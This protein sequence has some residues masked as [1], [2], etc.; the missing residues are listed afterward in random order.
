[1]IEVTL[2]KRTPS[3]GN[4]ITSLVEKQLGGN[5]RLSIIQGWLSGGR[6]RQWAPHGFREEGRRARY[7]SAFLDINQLP[8]SHVCLSLESQSGRFVNLPLVDRIRAFYAWWHVGDSRAWV[9]GMWKQVTYLKSLWHLSEKAARHL[10]KTSTASVSLT[11]VSAERK[12]IKRWTSAAIA[13]SFRGINLF[14][15]RGWQLN[16]CSPGFPACFAHRAAQRPAV[17]DVVGNISHRLW[18]SE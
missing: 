18:G 13:Y 1:M 17:A 9:N 7:N 5:V 4:P 16:F 11:T 2:G 8:G 12:T 15:N 3:S 14:C 10:C 6:G